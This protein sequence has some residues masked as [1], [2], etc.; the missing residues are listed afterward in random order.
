MPNEVSFALSR[1][2]GLEKRGID[3]V[4]AGI[5]AL[6]IVDAQR[7]EPLRDDALVLQR[8]IDAERL[9]PVAERGVVKIKPLFH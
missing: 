1:G 5:A 9:R 6:D 4:R 3:R 2:G 7:I 8:K